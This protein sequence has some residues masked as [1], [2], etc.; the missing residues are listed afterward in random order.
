MGATKEK[1]TFV[2]RS[3]DRGYFAMVPHIVRAR[4]DNPFQFTLWVAIKELVGEP[5]RPLDWG[6]RNLASYAMM[7]VGKASAAR[8]ALAEKGLIE[9]TEFRDDNNRLSYAITIPDLWPANIAWAQEHPS[10]DSRL[11]EKR[12]QITLAKKAKAAQKK[13]DTPPPTP[14]TSPPASP[15]ALQEPLLELQQD[16]G[17]RSPHERYR[18][19]HEPSTTV[20]HM[21]DTVHHM[22]D[23]RGDH[24]SCGERSLYIRTD[25]EQT[26]KN[27][28]FRFQTSGEY[29]KSRG[30]RN[31]AMAVDSSGMNK[32]DQREMAD[33]ILEWAGLTLVANTDS[34]DGDRAL[35][36]A[37]ESVRALVG[38]GLNVNGVRELCKN[39]V[40]DKPAGWTPTIGQLSKYASQQI[41]KWGITDGSINRV[42]G[43]NGNGNGGGRWAEVGPDTERS[44]AATDY[45]KTLPSVSPGDIEF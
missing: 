9:L 17:H 43:T 23:D 41:A 28:G 27:G 16:D 7:S 14:S 15:V 21:N 24:R 3:R 42:S 29:A 32:R 4:V 44:R 25:Q 40:D 30:E 1:T 5:N 35:S 36:D 34:R 45:Y 13:K 26:Y 31:A 6:I 8:A 10:P 12:E 19:P 38:M 20:H 37:Y 18:S 22:N 2:D 39:W 33:V 11:A